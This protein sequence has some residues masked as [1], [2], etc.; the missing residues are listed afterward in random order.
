MI[1]FCCIGGNFF[2]V[3]VEPEDKLLNAI[4]IGRLLKQ[5]MLIYFI[6]VDQRAV[7]ALSSVANSQ[8]DLERSIRHGADNLAFAFGIVFLP[9]SYKTQR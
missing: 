1:I 8:S 7:Q 3:Q 9:D 6:V 2:G 5:P 4:D